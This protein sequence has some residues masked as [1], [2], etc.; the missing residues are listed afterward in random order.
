[1]GATGPMPPLA[2]RPAMATP[3]AMPAPPRPAGPAPPPGPE[4]AVEVPAPS[5]PRGSCGVGFHVG[6]SV[7]P[8]NAGALPGSGKSTVGFT[9][10]WSVDSSCACS[11]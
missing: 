2:A 5:P 1:M 7:S 11:I 3:P 4:R 6:T 8:L 9:A 10:S